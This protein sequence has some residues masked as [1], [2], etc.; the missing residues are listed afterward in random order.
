LLA[1]LKP[2]ADK[3]STFIGP[4]DVFRV[5]G[6]KDDRGVTLEPFYK[7]HG[8]RH[9]VVYWDVFTPAQW[10]VKEQEYA[11]ELARQKELE[12]RTIDYVNPG[13][14]QHERDHK[15]QGERHS[16][17]DFGGRKWRHAPGGWFSWEVEVLPGQPQELRVTYWGSDSGRVFDVL[18]DGEKIATQKLNNNHPDQFYDEVHLL[19]EKLT[20]GKERITVKF[21]AHPGNTAGGVFGLR[22]LRSQ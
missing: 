16:A 12:A 2:V 19:P 13:E 6:D 7:M 11:A 10:Q 18:V 8:N 5:A 14:E 21:Q 17:G 15:L 9:Y 22:V 4:P 20:H 3:P 1:S